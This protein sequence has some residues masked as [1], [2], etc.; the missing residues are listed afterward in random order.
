LE[1][2]P[3]T[4][5][6]AST[7]TSTSSDPSTAGGP[8]LG[9][10]TSDTTFGGGTSSDLATSSDTL[11]SGGAGA[12]SAIVGTW[13]GD[14]DEVPATSAWTVR[15]L[16]VPPGTGGSS[17]SGTGTG[18]GTGFGGSGTGS[19]T[20][21]TYT[22]R[23]QSILQQNCTSCHSTGGSQSGTPLDTYQGAKALGSACAARMRD[24]SRPM[25]PGSLL[26]AD[27]AQDVATW[28]AAGSPQ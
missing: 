11:A 6:S 14:S 25:P 5:V 13:T 18:T 9:S 22:N 7:N 3:P 12:G 2:T 15:S 8:G 24:S 28:V 17:G 20:A 23:I 26:P 21:V 1:T 4:A 27:I 10:T 16:T 19:G